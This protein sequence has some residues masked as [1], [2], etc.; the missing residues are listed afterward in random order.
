MGAINYTLLTQKDHNDKIAFCT[1]ELIC[2]QIPDMSS[3]VTEFKT[4][5]YSSFS[6]GL[7]GFID[8]LVNSGTISRLIENLYY[9]FNSFSI[10][11]LAPTTE[12]Q[13]QQLVK[14]HLKEKLFDKYCYKVALANNE[15]SNYVRYLNNRTSRKHLDHEEHIHN[16]VMNAIVKSKIE[17]INS[18]KG[19]SL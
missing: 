2:E 8:N 9:H 1:A 13:F 15:F 10:Q 19:L 14:A 4:I 18:L 17:I 5:E 11:L 3:K 6:P 12:N 16:S 7:S